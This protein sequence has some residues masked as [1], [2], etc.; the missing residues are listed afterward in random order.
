MNNSYDK[1]NYSSSIFNSPGKS[2]MLSTSSQNLSGSYGYSNLT[3]QNEMITIILEQEHEDGERKAEG[4]KR[5]NL[6]EEIKRLKNFY[7]G[8]NSP[9]FPLKKLG[10]MDRSISSLNDE[11]DDEDIFYNSNSLYMNLLSGGEEG[12]LPCEEGEVRHEE[13]NSRGE[14][15][16]VLFNQ[17]YTRAKTKTQ[18]ESEQALRGRNALEENL[19]Y[20]CI[21]EKES[22]YNKDGNR[23]A[24]KCHREDQQG[25]GEAPVWS[26]QKIRN[27]NE[28]EKKNFYL[29]KCR[30]QMS[31]KKEHKMKQPLSLLKRREDGKRDEDNDS[32]NH[33]Q[34]KEEEE[35]EEKYKLHDRVNELSGGRNNRSDYDSRDTSTVNPSQSRKRGEEEGEGH[36]PQ[37]KSDMRDPTVQ[38]VSSKE[39]DITP[40]GNLSNRKREKMSN[41]SKLADSQKGDNCT[42]RESVPREDYSSKSINYIIQEIKKEESKEKNFTMDSY[43]TVYLSI[44]TKVLEKDVDYF[45]TSRIL[46]NEELLNEKK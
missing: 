29:Q 34:V 38:R 42:K 15:D 32:D 40:Q 23:K 2:S 6:N 43:G 16:S 35:V 11:N 3:Q 5:T 19:F 36:Y 10:K 20:D 1:Y 25:E 31:E 9:N 24:K 12:E 46:P 28:D 39:E 8:V 21:A 13:G 30:D 33:H 7:K 14:E 4:N 41:V 18:E 37:R 44:C 17:V 26:L 45:L 22:V 27:Q